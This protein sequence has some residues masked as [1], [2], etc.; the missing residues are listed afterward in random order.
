MVSIGSEVILGLIGLMIAIFSLSHID[1]FTLVVQ[2]QKSLFIF[3]IIP[4]YRSYCT[5]LKGCVEDITLAKDNK[6]LLNWQLICS[7]LVLKFVKLFE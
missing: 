2:N 7:L 5:E 4:M 1:I 3:W 6:R